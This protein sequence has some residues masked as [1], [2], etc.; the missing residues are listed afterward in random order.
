MNL[1]YTGCAFSMLPENATGAQI[2]YYPLDE[3]GGVTATPESST[4]I[5][6]KTV[7]VYG[8][9]V[10]KTGTALISIA[11]DDPGGLVTSFTPSS[12]GSMMFG[13]LGIEAR[14]PLKFLVPTSST[15]VIQ[16]LWKKVV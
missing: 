9:N 5:G 3:L 6:S 4:Q 12:I 15:A 7:I 2:T 8:V 1:A 14:G 11:K 13:V 10:L 16:V